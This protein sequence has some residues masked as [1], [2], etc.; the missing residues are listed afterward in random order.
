MFPHR[1]NTN[2]KNLRGLQE[3]VI[4]FSFRKR[5]HFLLQ[6]LSVGRQCKPTGTG[7]PPE[8]GNVDTKKRSHIPKF[9]V[10]FLRPITKLVAIFQIFGVKK[11]EICYLSIVRLNKTSNIQNS[12]LDLSNKSRADDEIPI[13]RHTQMTQDRKY[14]FLVA[15][16]ALNLGAAK[17]NHYNQSKAF[18]DW[19]KFWVRLPKLEGVQ[20]NIPADMSLSMATATLQLLP[21][22]LMR[23][24]LSSWKISLMRGMYL[25]KWSAEWKF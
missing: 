23:E 1:K 17:Y 6:G 14:L 21:A 22:S 24:G 13:W 4:S 9:Y 15:S 11:W 12:M 16:F 8:I 25:H 2:E 5:F 19:M 18:A 3:L 20:K 10:Q 7:R